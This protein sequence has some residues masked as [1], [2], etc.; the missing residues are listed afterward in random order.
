MKLLRRLHGLRQG[1]DKSTSKVPFESNNTVLQDI[2]ASSCGYWCMSLL[3]ALST[4]TKLSKFVSNFSD[5]FDE[6]EAILTRI[7]QVSD[8][9]H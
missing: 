5:N 3:Y 9:L 8:G 6:N 2:D 1:H 4:G 7:F